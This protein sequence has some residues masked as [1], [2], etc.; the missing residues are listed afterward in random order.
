[1]Y[2]MSL[3]QQRFCL[4]EYDGTLSAPEKKKT[5]YFDFVDT[6]LQT[7][8]E[9]AGKQNFATQGEREAYLSL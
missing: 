3:S 5:T 9:D 6:Q 2:L 1:M 8:R 7:L 4:V